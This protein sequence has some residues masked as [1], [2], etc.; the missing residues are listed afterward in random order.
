MSAPRVIE[1]TFGGCKMH[2]IGKPPAWYQTPEEKSASNSYGVMASA[3]KP[4]NYSSAK[5]VLEHMD[6]NRRIAL[7]A[8]NPKIFGAIDKCVPYHFQNLKFSQEGILINQ[9]LFARFTP[10]LGHMQML[11]AFL[12]ANRVHSVD[13]LTANDMNSISGLPKNLQLKVNKMVF[14]DQTLQVLQA[15]RQVILAECFPL[16]HMCIFPD[17]PEDTIFNNRIT[18][19]DT[20]TMALILPEPKY[21]EPQFAEPLKMLRHPNVEI[22]DFEITFS[23]FVRV[24]QDWMRSPRPIGTKFGMTTNRYQKYIGAVYGALDC[25]VFSD[26]YI[27]VLQLRSLT[28]IWKWALLEDCDPRR[29]ISVLRAG[30]SAFARPRAL[31]GSDG[32]GGNRTCGSILHVRS[33]FPNSIFLVLL[34]S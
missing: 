13:C 8:K 2:I 9:K 5:A 31:N 18:S 3:T 32:G 7:V 22:N 12:G 34:F 10:N 4:L 27:H 28:Q 30:A 14:R 24:A 20:D 11:K 16:K 23:D 6:A 15:V 29:Q 25:K 26:R 19:A 33:P 21:G 1:T 17:H